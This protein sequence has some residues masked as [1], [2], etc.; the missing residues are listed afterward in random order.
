MRNFKP[1]GVQ[2]AVITM[3]YHYGGT[4][5]NGPYRPTF[6]DINFSGFTTGKSRN[7]LNLY[8]FPDHPIGP[9]QVSGWA[10]GGVSGQGVLAQN[11]QGLQLTNVTV[12][13]KP[14]RG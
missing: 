8:G 4:P 6:R 5:E 3:T 13:G 12:N 14:V 7:A 2:N 10:F 9:V 1:A 11:V